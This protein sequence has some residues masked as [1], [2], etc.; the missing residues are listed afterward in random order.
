MKDAIKMAISHFFIISVCVMTV[1]GISNL[2]IGESFRG[3][4][5]DFPFQILLV[6]STSALPSLLYYFRTEPTRKQFLI[7]VFL[8][9]I[10]IMTIVLG[11]GYLLGWYRSA[12]D[13]I[14]V[15]AAVVIVYAAVWLISVHSGNKVE[16]GINEALKRINGEEE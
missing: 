7:R 1:I 4:G 10:S 11:E 3:Y 12:V 9:F 8:H 6:G 5:L 14:P 2:F 15:A 13:M 16:R